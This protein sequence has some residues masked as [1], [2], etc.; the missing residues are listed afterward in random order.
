[1]RLWDVRS[2]DPLVHYFNKPFPETYHVS[3]ATVLLGCSGETGY[4]LWDHRNFSVPLEVHDDYIADCWVFDISD[5]CV[6]ASDESGKLE[7]LLRKY[8]NTHGVIRQQRDVE[9]HA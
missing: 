3:M 4:K 2:P 6:T 7:I 9:I 8:G 5:S 1:M